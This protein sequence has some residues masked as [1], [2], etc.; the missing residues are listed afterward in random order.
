MTGSNLFIKFMFHLNLSHN[1]SFQGNMFSVLVQTG[2]KF[3]RN[4]LHSFLIDASRPS[5]VTFSE[6]PG[7]QIHMLSK[8]F[9]ASIPFLESPCLYQFEPSRPYQRK[10]AMH[11]TGRVYRNFPSALAAN[12]I[13]KQPEKPPSI[14][15]GWIENRLPWSFQ[16]LIT[17]QPDVA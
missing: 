8:I 3:R 14:R 2:H 6:F 11:S 17:L 16:T 12:T 1:Q 13:A 7:R 5:Q 10:S 4:G 15:F 9:L